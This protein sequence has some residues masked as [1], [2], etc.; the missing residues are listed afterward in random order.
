MFFFRVFSS[1]QQKFQKIKIKI[2]IKDL[3]WDCYQNKTKETKTKPNMEG[4]Q[5]WE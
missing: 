4:N 1:E 5:K 2:K 3:G